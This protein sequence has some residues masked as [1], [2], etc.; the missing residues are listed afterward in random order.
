MAAVVIWRCVFHLVTCVFNLVVT[1]ILSGS[2]MYF[3]RQP[4]IFYLIASGCHMYFIWRSNIFYLVAGSIFNLAIIWI[5]CVINLA[6]WQ[7]PSVFYL[8]II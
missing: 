3:I 6:V 8:A 2:Y 7:Q 4:G 5:L 1:C